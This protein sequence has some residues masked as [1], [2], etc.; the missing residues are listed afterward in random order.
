MLRGT[1]TEMLRAVTA[2]AKKA[3]ARAAKE[4]ALK[5][6]AGKAAPAPVKAA[7]PPLTGAAAKA[8]AAKATKPGAPEAEAEGEPGPLLDLSDTAVKKMIKAAKKRGYVTY[9]QLNEVMPS[10]EVTSEQIEDLL[11]MMNEMGIN[12]VESEEAEAEEEGDDDDEEGGELVEKSA[13]KVAT[14]GA[15]EPS[16][17][18]DDPVRMYLREMGT[19]ELLVARGRDRHRQAHRGRPRGDD[20]GPVREPADLPGHHRLARRAERSQSACCARSSIWKPPT[21]GPRP[22]RSR[23]RRPPPCSPRASRKSPPPTTA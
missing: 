15:K 2:K 8:A 20:R 17:R 3:L 12:V 23:R 9:D 21:P 4:A 7:P 10:E 16:E 1:V 13:T 22:R 14:T 18:T 6:V 5:P 19:V 11:A